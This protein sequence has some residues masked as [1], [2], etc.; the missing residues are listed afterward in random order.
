MDTA[1]LLCCRPL[2]VRS[3]AEELKRSLDQVIQGLQFAADRV[4]WC[5][6][7]RRRRLP[8]TPQLRA[9]SSSLLAPPF[10]C[11]IRRTRHAGLRRWTALQ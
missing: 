11:R 8:P 10:Y 5:A 2:Q 4:Q 1:L 7:R 3:R 6:A 9:A